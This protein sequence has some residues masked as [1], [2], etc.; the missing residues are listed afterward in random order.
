MKL[1]KMTIKNKKSL[2]IFSSKTFKIHI[3]S[4]DKTQLL[5]KIRVDNADFTFSLKNLFIIKLKNF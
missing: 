1:E 4:Q 3:S 5:T 2:C